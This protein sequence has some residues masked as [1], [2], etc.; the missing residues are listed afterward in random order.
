MNRNACVMVTLVAM[1]FVEDVPADSHLKEIRYCGPPERTSTGRIKRNSYVVRKF[2]QIHPLPPQYDRKDWAVDHVIPLAR[3]GCD[4]VWNL[5]WL[6]KS[7]KSCAGDSCKDRW[8]R[9]VYEE[10]FFGNP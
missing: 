4:T 8:E 2:E 9:K 5:Q 3:G 1:L 6:H 7:I 10:R